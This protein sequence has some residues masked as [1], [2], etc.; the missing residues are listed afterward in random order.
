MKAILLILLFAFACSDFPYDIIENVKC[1]VQSESVQAFIPKVI[2]AIKTGDY[3]SLFSAIIAEFPQLQADVMK[4][5]A[6]EPVL[7]YERTCLAN[8]KL[9]S[10]L[11]KRQ[12]CI[13]HCLFEDYD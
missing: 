12:N 13:K 10:D 2:E 5:L 6:D 1:L 11:N 9:I 8:C 7:K 3:M 4:C